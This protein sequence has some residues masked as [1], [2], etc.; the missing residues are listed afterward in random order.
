MRVRLFAK[1]LGETETE[2]TIG[3]LSHFLSLVVF[4]AIGGG[5]VLLNPPGYA[6][7]RGELLLKSGLNRWLR[8]LTMLL[9]GPDLHCVGPLALRRYL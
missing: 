2:E 1:M 8:L 4:H 9:T 3:F 6:Q 5:V 7:G